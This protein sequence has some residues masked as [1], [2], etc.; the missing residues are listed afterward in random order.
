MIKRLRNSNKL[1]QMRW[2]AWKTAIHMP[3]QNRIVI[4]SGGLKNLDVYEQ[5]NLRTVVARGS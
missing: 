2:Q 1:N 4:M 5:H 3:K